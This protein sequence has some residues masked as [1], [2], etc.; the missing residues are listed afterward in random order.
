M[1]VPTSIK[2]M[3]TMIVVARFGLEIS[4]QIVVDNRNRK[5]QEIIK[6]ISNYQ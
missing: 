6:L 3:C 5:H 1:D 4:P 2:D